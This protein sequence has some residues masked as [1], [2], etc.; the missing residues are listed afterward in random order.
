[1]GLTPALQ[2]VIECARRSCGGSAHRIPSDPNWDDVLRHTEDQSLFAAVGAVLDTLPDRESGS[3]SRRQI[4]VRA[5]VARMQRRLRQE[6]GMQRVLTVLADARCAPIVLKGPALAYSRYVQPEFRSFADLDILLPASEVERA[7]QALLASGFAINPETPLP[8]G[9]QHV[10]PLFAPQNEIVVELHHDV[11]EAESPFSPVVDE[12]RARAEPTTM[13]GH[14]IHVLSA[15][16]AVL[17]TCVHLSHG[18]TYLR[19]PLRSLTDILALTLSGAVSWP[20]LVQRAREA[21]MSGAVVWPLAAARAW[22]KA[23]IPAP[24]FEQ[25]MPGQPLR[26]FIGTA[27]GSGYILDRDSVADDGTAVAYERL[28]ELSMLGHTSVTGCG[29]ILLNGLFPPA[30]GTADCGATPP[31]STTR[32]TL[33]LVRPMRIL[34]GLRAMG[35]LL[36]HREDWTRSDAFSD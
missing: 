24:V 5:T 9:H 32:H 36:G 28:I 27:M 14:P 7:T 4:Q 13:L 19:Y 31:T 25:L 15:T 6:P 18:H 23:P 2:F 12:W 34:R 33:K 22:L 1:M 35:Q 17:H 8:G 29:K 11:F 26:W 10:P 3:D 21:Q 30:R 20:D 16:D